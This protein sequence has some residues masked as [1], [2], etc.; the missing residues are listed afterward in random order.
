MGEESLEPGATAGPSPSPARAAP[1]GGTR[2]A[3]IWTSTVVAVAVLI[4]LV[5]FMVQNQDRVTV[6]FLGFQGQLALGVAMLIA[7]VGG[8]VVVSIVGAVRIIQLRARAHIANK[9]RTKNG[10]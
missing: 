6:Y 10:P 7:T 2:A 8:A 3:V 5:I 9:A 4:L 1:A